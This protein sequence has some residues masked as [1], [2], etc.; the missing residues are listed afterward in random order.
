MDELRQRIAWLRNRN[1]RPEPTNAETPAETP[2]G[3]LIREGDRVQLR[4]HTLANRPAFQRWYADDEIARLLRHDQRA[5]THLQSRSYFDTI[6]LPASANGHA[7][8]IHDRASGALIG[9]CALMDFE[10]AQHRSAYLRILIGEKSWWGHGYGTEAT[11]L[12]VREAF[13]RLGLDEV[14]LEVFSTN[15]RAVRAYR[16]VGFQ[17][18]G[19][20]R[21]WVGRDRF[22]LHVLE[23]SLYRGE[24][25]AI[26]AE[27]I[28]AAP[29]STPAPD[30]ITMQTDGL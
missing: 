22:E 10:G 29:E 23:M 16:R 3:E 1:A 30:A 25:E 28:E 2:Q 13:E 7:W 20:H 5:L 27:R 19:E 21:E 11:E 12:V 26:D 8:A 6:M 18:T 9:A 4:R 14:K 17:Q 24:L 15:E